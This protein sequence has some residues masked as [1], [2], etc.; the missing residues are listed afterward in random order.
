MKIINHLRNYLIKFSCFF[1]GV[2]VSFMYFL[3]IQVKKLA[4]ETVPILV[5]LL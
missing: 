1:V 4:L 3:A 5:K 2:D